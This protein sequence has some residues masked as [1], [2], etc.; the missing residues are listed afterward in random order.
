M[1]V[2]AIYGGQRYGAG[3][4]ADIFQ[5]ASE[6]I[7]RCSYRYRPAD[8]PP[9]SITQCNIIL[10]G[11]HYCPQHAEIMIKRAKRSSELHEAREYLKSLSEEE[12][13]ELLS[14]AGISSDIQSVPNE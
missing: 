2:S 14:D 1:M 8:S 3:E 7:H 10:I 6:D 4:S 12:I 9:D 5:M 11:G 13:I